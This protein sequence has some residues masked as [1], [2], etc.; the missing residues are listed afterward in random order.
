[1][2][3]LIDILASAAATGFAIYA[4]GSTIAGMAACAATVVYGCWCFYDGL[5]SRT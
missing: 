5:T 4:T 1:M 2:R 3:F